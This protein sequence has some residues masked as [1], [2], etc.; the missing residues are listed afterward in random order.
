ME[1]NLYISNFE[2]MKKFL[3]YIFTIILFFLL[4]DGGGRIMLNSVLNHI[5]DNS[6]HLSKV[7]KSI[8]IDDVNFIVVGMSTAEHNYNIAI[9]EDSLQMSGYNCGSDGRNLFY[10]YMVVK[11]AII[12][13]N[14]LKLVIVDVNYYSLTSVTKDRINSVYPFYWKNPIVRGVIRDLQGSKMD[15]LMLSSLYQMNSGLQNVWRL[16][17]PLIS[18]EYKGFTP[19]PYMDSA[20]NLTNKDSQTEELFVDELASQ[21]LE[22]IIDECQ[23]NNI[24]VVLVTSPNLDNKKDVQLYSQL[25]K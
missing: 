18:K 10:D 13:N 25:H 22:K 2:D 8:S 15:I 1:D 14:E 21:Y 19:Y 11:N 9:L 3:L 4:I 7:N 23:A 6:S 24:P 20:V 12:H 16:Y 5:P 17:H